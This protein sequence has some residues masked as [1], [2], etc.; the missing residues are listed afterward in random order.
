MAGNFQGTYSADQVIVTVG[1][2]IV[3]GFADGDFITAQ[4]D[5]DRFT[6][7]V[8]ADGEVGR[9]KNPSRAGNIEITL[10]ASSR[11]NDELSALFNL[12]SL[13]GVDAPIAIAVSDLSGR[14]VIGASKG[15]IKS[16]PEVTFGKEI[17]ERVWVLDCAD[18]Q[19]FVG[20]ND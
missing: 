13:A 2:V 15:W 14:T 9:S 18:L 5:E 3:S 4:Y 16:A 17:G 8:G 6:K 19:M 20:G 10:A 7:M 1:G 12:D 11:A